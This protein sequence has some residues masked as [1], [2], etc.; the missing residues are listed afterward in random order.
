MRVEFQICKQKGER[1]VSLSDSHSHTHAHLRE[2]F[3]NG[4]TII[5]QPLYNS[6]FSVYYLPQYSFGLETFITLYK[7]LSYTSILAL[8]STF[9]PRQMKRLVTTSEHLISNQPIAPPSPHF[10]YFWLTHIPSL[11]NFKNSYCN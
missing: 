9:T 3:D 5:L 2:N 1:L 6:V 4:N 7:T 10:L 11:A 8:N